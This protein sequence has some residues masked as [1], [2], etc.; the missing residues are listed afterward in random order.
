MTHVEYSGGL[1]ACFLLTVEKL[2]P[3]D[4][5]PAAKPCRRDVVFIAQ[6]T[7]PLSGL[8]TMRSALSARN[9]KID[10]IGR[11]ASIEFDILENVSALREHFSHRM[12]NLRGQWVVTQP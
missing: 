12:V 2:P 3:T 8:N 5:W 6:I 7:S 1:P 4:D 9:Q 10:R 11:R